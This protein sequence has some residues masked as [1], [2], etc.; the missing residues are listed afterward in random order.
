MLI[1]PPK[2]HP[3]TWI[4]SQLRGLPLS[5]HPLA[6]APAPLHQQLQHPTFHGLPCRGGREGG[7][8]VLAGK[9]EIMTNRLGFWGTTFE[10]M[11]MDGT[12]ECA[13]TGPPLRCVSSLPLSA[14]EPQPHHFVTRPWHGETDETPSPIAVATELPWIWDGASW[15]GGCSCYFHLHQ[16]VS[17]G[18]K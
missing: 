7:V 14:F 12:W 10:T 1:S 16:Q 4:V 6:A 2:W 18:Q 15:S 13:A 5:Q 17:E 11:A 3:K 8:A 9:V